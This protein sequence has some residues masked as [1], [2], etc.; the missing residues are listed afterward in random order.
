M[1]DLGVHMTIILKWMSK[2]CGDLHCMEMA[3]DRVEFREFML[4]LMN[5]RVP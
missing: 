3:Q 5:L 4:T 1:G 2:M